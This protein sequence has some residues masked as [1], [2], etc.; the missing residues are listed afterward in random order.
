MHKLIAYSQYDEV[1][2]VEG[3]YPQCREALERILETL[4]AKGRK[5]LQSEG[6]NRAMVEG[7]FG[8]RYRYRIS[9]PVE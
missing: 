9:S 2:M 5:V 3:N 6:G 8:A 1:V 7:K 4:R